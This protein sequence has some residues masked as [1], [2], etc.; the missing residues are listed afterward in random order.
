MKY[1]GR[2]GW[3]ASY[4]DTWD[5]DNTLSPIIAAG[6]SKF[7]SIK[8]KPVFGV[9]NKVY[10]EY[11]LSEDEDDLACFLWCEILAHMLWAFTAEEPDVNDYN[12]HVKLDNH[13]LVRSGDLTERDRYYNDIKAFHEWRQIGLDLFS[14]YYSNLWW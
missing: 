4:K 13:K 6:L 8:D 11:G 7:L 2:K 12:Y 5:L 3:V 10:V 14:K 1:T 9:P